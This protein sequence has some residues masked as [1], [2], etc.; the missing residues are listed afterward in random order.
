MFRRVLSALD[1]MTHPFARILAPLLAPVALGAQGAAPRILV[2]P[3][4]LVSHDGA[5]PHAELMVAANPRDPRNLIGGAVTFTRA[6]GG[7][8]NK[9]YVSFDGG[10]SWEDVRFPRQY[11]VGGADPQAA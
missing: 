8:E 6:E 4:V 5:V 11:H 9:A 7:L 10:S 1:D 2:T 3:N